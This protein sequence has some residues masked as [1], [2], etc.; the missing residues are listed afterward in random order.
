MTNTLPLYFLDVLP[1][2]KMEAIKNKLTNTIHEKYIPEYQ[3]Y[4]RKYPKNIQMYHLAW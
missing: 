2:S 1:N 4:L 3:M